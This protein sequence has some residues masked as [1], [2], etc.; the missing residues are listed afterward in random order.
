MP[1]SPRRTTSRRTLLRSAAAV[2]LLAACGRGGEAGPPDGE[3]VALVGAR[4][5][6]DGRYE[7]ADLVVGV[8][9]ILAVGAAVPGALPTLDC[10]GRCLIPGVIDAHVHMQFATPEAILAGGVTTVRDLGSP[11]DGA[12]ALRGAGPL[13]VLAAGRILTPPRGYPSE[14]WGAD[15]TA[16]Q[17]DG[18]EDAAAAV[19]EELAAG[20]D[21]IKVALEDS[22]GRPLLGADVLAAIV[23]AAHAGGRQ[24]TAH[25][26]TAAALDLALAAGVNELAHLPLHDVT[27]AEMVRAAERGLVLV[28][29]LAIRGEDPGAP[30]A[31]RAFREAGGR[32]VYGTDLG[33][34]GTTPGIEVAEVRA[35]LAAGMT[36]AEVLDAATRDAAEHLG[37]ADVGRIEVDATADLALV[38]PDPLGDPAHYADVA[39]VL[40]GGRVVADSR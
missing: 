31:V 8:G 11:R 23:A 6:V 7:D 26:G 27:P 38:G 16:R 17:V 35:L 24:V 14:S 40:A 5:V 22:R 33:N 1:P 36:P 9:R 30:A 12:L 20:V 13:R 19:A 21:V 18:A 32:V 29:T 28:P 37:L 34:G 10:A 39:L 3:P 4:I 25:V 2:A 15:G